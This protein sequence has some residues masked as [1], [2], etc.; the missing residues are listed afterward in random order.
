LSRPSSADVFGLCAVMLGANGLL[1]S[2]ALRLL[3][4]DSRGD[5]IGIALLMTLI[6]AAALAGTARWIVAVSARATPAG[7]RA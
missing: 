5:W 3:G 1:F 4:G 2:G 7:A 6:M